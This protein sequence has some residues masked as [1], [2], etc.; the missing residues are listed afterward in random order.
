V[1]ATRGALTGEHQRWAGWSLCLL[2]AAVPAWWLAL[3]GSE[4]V[5]GVFVPPGEWDRIR[6]FLFP[7]LGLAAITGVAG[8]RGLGGSLSGTI[9]GLAVGA[10]GYATLWTVGATVDGGVSALGVMLML[11]AF[12]IVCVASRA[13]V[14]PSRARDR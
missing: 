13:L 10:W 14:S 5:R 12:T 9:A 4:P 7:D 8:V 11:A 1:G 2:A 6:P 3:Y